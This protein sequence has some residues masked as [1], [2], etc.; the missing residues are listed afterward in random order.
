MLLEIIISTL[1]FSHI[2]IIF[3][4][5]ILSVTKIS[6]SPIFPV[7]YG[8]FRSNLFA[9]AI[10]ILRL[11][12]LYIAFVTINSSWSK[13]KSVPSL[14]IADIPTIA[15]SI[16]KLLIKSDANEPTIALSALLNFPPATQTSQFFELP[17]ILTILIL[18][19]IIF[20]PWWV[21]KR[22]LATC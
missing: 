8:A 18:F 21:L 20:K 14:S 6:M 17:A 15:L 3:L 19:V 12:C 16:L 1:F 4:S 13:S 10:N 9:S 2:L 11:L 5:G 7:T 22:L